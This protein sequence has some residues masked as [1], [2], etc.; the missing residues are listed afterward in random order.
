MVAIHSNRLSL[1]RTFQLKIRRLFK[2]LLGFPGSQ[3]VSKKK[4]NKYPQSSHFLQGSIKYLMISVHL[5]GF[6][7]GEVK[8]EEK[9]GK[10]ER[11]EE[12][13]KKKKNK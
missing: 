10:I 5:G 3:Q 2:L 8:R 4:N 9:E 7:R 6:S 13:N 1:Y 12:Y 11:K